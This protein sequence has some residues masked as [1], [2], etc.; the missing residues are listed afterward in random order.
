M[1]MMEEQILF[2]LVLDGSKE[3]GW[4]KQSWAAISNKEFILLLLWESCNDCGIQPKFMVQHGQPPFF[5]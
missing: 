3:I 1:E 5:I 4:K 2:P